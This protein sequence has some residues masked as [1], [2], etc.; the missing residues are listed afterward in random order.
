MKK[1]LIGTVLMACWWA[2]P[3]A[4]YAQ[5][6]TPSVEITYSS[7][8]VPAPEVNTEV[9]VDVQPP[10]PAP[11]PV[12][13]VNIQVHESAPTAPSVSTSQSVKETSVTKIVE[14]AP[15]DSGNNAALIL[16]GGLVAVGL[17]FGLYS[18][19]KGR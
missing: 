5:E 13:D 19:A 2:G 11:A 7:T 10:V 8:P 1:L 12:P 14:T 9:H 3:V 16:V 15:A 4:V 18:L 6:Q 17:A